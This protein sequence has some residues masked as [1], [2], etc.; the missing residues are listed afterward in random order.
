VG[1]GGQGKAVRR[2]KTIILLAV[3]DGD[4]KHWAIYGLSTE[5]GHIVQRGGTILGE[6]EGSN[7]VTFRRPERAADRSA[8]VAMFSFTHSHLQKL[9]DVGHPA[10][11]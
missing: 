11:N 2:E 10:P 5:S 4:Q 7:V 1:P 8:R 6:F 3:L 9:L